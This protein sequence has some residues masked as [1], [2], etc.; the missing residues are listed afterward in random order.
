VEVSAALALDMI[1]IGSSNFGLR[2]IF[3]TGSTLKEGR[4]SKLLI[5]GAGSI[6]LVAFVPPREC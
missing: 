6:I 1:A 3:A 4:I 2:Y 5:G